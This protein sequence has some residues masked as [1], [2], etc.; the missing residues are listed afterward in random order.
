MQSQVSLQEEGGGSLDPDGGGEDDAT[1]KAGTAVTQV[2]AEDASNTATAGWKRKGT[3][4]ARGSPEGIQP[5]AHLDSG[6]ATL[7]LGYCPPEL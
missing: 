5:C 2:P 3:D 6:P 4:P 7:A 1:T